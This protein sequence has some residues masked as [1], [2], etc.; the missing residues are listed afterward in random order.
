LGYPTSRWKLLESVVFFAPQKLLANVAV[1]GGL[2]VAGG[3]CFQLRRRRRGGLWRFSIG[4]LLVIV[5]AVAVALGVFSAQRAE[6]RRERELVN[7]I[8]MA[9]SPGEQDWG[10][11][12]SNRVQWHEGGPAWLRKRVGD[13]WLRDFDRVVGFET[14]GTELAE[15]VRFA[16]LECIFIEGAASNRQLKQLEECPSLE[17][18]TIWNVRMRHDKNPLREVESDWDVG[19]RI[20]KLPRLRGLALPATPFLGEG[21]ENV[22]NLESLD[23]FETGVGDDDMPLVGKMSKL[24]MLILE[25]TDVTSAGLRHLAN[26]TELRVLWLSKTQIDDRGIR[27]LTGLA[28]LR[29][30]FLDGTNVTDKSVPHLKRLRRL[31][32]LLVPSSVSEDARKE[33]QIALAKCD[34]HGI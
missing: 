5:A 14:D 32:Q 6:G 15:V 8:V 29:E 21:L 27:H 20:P 26:L 12:A 23:L 10:Y 30:L 33:L 13:E 25:D 22:P 28:K 7:R 34:V 16:H 1:A 19:F 31:E 17:A 2:L 4:D 3:I 11:D 9:Q 24:K 18:V